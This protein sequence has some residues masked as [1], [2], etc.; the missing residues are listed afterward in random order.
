N[1]KTAAAMAA[2]ADGLW[3]A[4]GGDAPL[5]AAAA[6]RPHRSSTPASGS[7]G[8][9]KADRRRSPAPFKKYQNPTNGKCLFHNFYGARATKCTK[10]RNWT[11]N[12]KDPS[13]KRLRESPVSTKKSLPDIWSFRKIKPDPVGKDM[14]VAVAITF[15][16]SLTAASFFGWRLSSFPTNCTVWCTWLLLLHKSYGTNIFRCSDSDIF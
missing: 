15:S 16:G 7:D 13:R 1:L 8:G 14:A 3:D 10:P 9:K 11:E 2:A 4:R 5:C 12:K 6:L